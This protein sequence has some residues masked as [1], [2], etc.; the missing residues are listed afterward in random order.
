MLFRRVFPRWRGFTLIELLVVIAIIAILI[1]LLL[2][3]VQKVREAANRISCQNNLRQMGL[4]VQNCAQTNASNLPPALGTYPVPNVGNGPNGCSSTAATG[5]GGVLYFLLPFI[6][7]DNLYNSTKCPAPYM[8]YSTESANNQPSPNTMANAVKVYTCPS[9]PTSNNGM[10][11]G[12]W[13]GVGSY[14]YN[15]MVF[16]ADWVG[17]N[18]FPASIT[19]GPSNTILFTEVYAGGNGWGD[20]N[21]QWDESLWWWD[22]NTFQAPVTANGDCGPL[23]Y[24]GPTFTPLIQPTI[25]YCHNNTVNWS[26]GCCA[27]VCM[28]RAVSPHPTG[29]NVGM[30]DGSGRFVNGGISGTT[31]Y[32]ASTP[33]GGETLGVDW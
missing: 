28:C 8:G 19:D 14:V 10:G 4:A 15:G 21:W 12:G 7:Q 24:W 3:A 33:N 30:G 5:F 29:I 1:G 20:P 26:W 17:Y 9:D 22:Y 11:Y 2:P 32:A 25:S 31:W 13:A 18:R 23:N 6:E 27:S 16:Q